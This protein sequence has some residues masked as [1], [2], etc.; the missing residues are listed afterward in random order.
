ML[1]FFVFSSD[2]R[3]RTIFFALLYLKDKQWFLGYGISQYVIFP[4]TKLSA[5]LSSRIVLGVAHT[6]QISSNS[7]LAIIKVSF[8]YSIQRVSPSVEFYYS[9]L[10]LMI[11]LVTVG[12]RSS[13][14]ECTVSQAS[15]MPTSTN[16][17]SLARLNYTLVF[18]TFLIF[19]LFPHSFWE[20][21]HSSWILN[22]IKS[23]KTRAGRNFGISS[24]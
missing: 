19:C 1:F 8:E 16:S 12:H 17:I 24:S 3:N 6:K 7:F 11:L 15:A 2:L 13:Q 21:I 9:L 14:Y 23:Y 10:K 4:R 20:K 18:S 22:V 5:R